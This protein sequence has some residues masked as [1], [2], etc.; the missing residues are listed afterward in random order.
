MAG[1]HSPERAAY[2]ARRR[3]QFYFRGLIGVLEAEIASADPG[4]ATARGAERKTGLTGEDGRL[5]DWVWR[6]LR[7][8]SMFTGEDSRILRSVEFHLAEAKRRALGDP[9]EEARRRVTEYELKREIVGRI[10]LCQSLL[11]MSVTAE[12]DLLS[13]A[14]EDLTGSVESLEEQFFN[15]L[16]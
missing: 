15:R 13:R 4:A 2:E 1:Q 5:L 7:E 3:I 8:L 16:R 9:P 12:A 14:L 10:R 11:Q 6:A